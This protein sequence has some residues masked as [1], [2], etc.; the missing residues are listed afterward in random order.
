MREWLGRPRLTWY[1]IVFA[2]PDAGAPL[3]GYVD[4][5]RAPD[6]DFEVG[7]RRYGVFARD[8]RRGGAGD[9]LDLMAARELGAS[10]GRRVRSAV[11]RRCWR[12]PSPSSPTPY[13]TRCATLH[14]RA[15]LAAVPARSVRLMRD[16]AEHPAPRRWPS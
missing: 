11:Q 8:W 1:Y 2:D 9:W 5:Q 13:A 14:D 4:Y 3:M 10:A 6:A 16:R 7:G 15:A 12:S